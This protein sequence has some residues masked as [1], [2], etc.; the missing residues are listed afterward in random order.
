[1][2]DYFN[3]KKQDF[4]RHYMDDIDLVNVKTDLCEN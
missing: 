4:C 1:M 3:D 2:K